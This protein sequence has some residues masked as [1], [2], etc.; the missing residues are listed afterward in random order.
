M[1]IMVAAKTARKL[2]MRLV[3]WRSTTS[4]KFAFDNADA[5]NAMDS[6]IDTSGKT[7]SSAQTQCFWTTMEGPLEF[8]SLAM[9]G[10]LEATPDAFRAAT[11]QMASKDVEQSL[12]SPA[13]LGFDAILTPETLAARE[14]ATVTLRV[15]R[16]TLANLVKTLEFS[17]GK[18]A[19]DAFSVEGKAAWA[20]L[21]AL[22][23][24]GHMRGEAS[25]VD[26]HGPF[27]SEATFASVRSRLVPLGKSFACVCSDMCYTIVEAQP[28]FVEFLT[29][30]QKR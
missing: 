6:W 24:V 22:Q 5:L 13:G 11:V 15:T 20:H 12:T 25:D 10:S 9:A 1:S 8:I 14:A 4:A 27:G 28:W 29:V 19:L 23:L 18:W 30:V 16:D 17:S 3:A 2:R 7:L 26:V 21:Q